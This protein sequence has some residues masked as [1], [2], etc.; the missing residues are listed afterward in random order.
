MTPA[1]A[2]AIVH[3]AFQWWAEIFIPAGGAIATVAVSVVALAASSRA[4]KLAHQIEEARNSDLDQR[5]ADER[6]E[7]LRSLALEEARALQRWITEHE[8]RSPWRTSHRIS[9]PPPPRAPDAQA[10][11]DAT[12]MLEQSIVPGATEVLALTTYDLDNPFAYGPADDSDDGAF[13]RMQRARSA[14]TKSRIRDWAMDPQSAVSMLNRDETD[15]VWDT[16]KYFSIGEEITW[17]VDPLNLPKALW[18]Q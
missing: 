6:A 14:R 12:V 5:H 13:R 11:I 3:D 16:E 9:E 7:H 15:A 8:N 4:Q 18:Y 17:E 2:P 1:A 10:R